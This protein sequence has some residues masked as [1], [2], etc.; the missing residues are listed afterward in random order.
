MDAKVGMP[1]AQVFPAMRELLRQSVVETHAHVAIVAL[2]DIASEGIGG[3]LSIPVVYPAAERNARLITR[4]IRKGVYFAVETGATKLVAGKIKL[5]DDDRP[6]MGLLIAAPMY[7]S[8]G[9]PWGAIAILKAT[10]EVEWATVNV[11]EQCARAVTN[12]LIRDCAPRAQAEPL[13]SGALIS[14]TAQP[15]QQT[16]PQTDFLLHELRVPLSTV[17]Y[18][19]EAL[20]QRHGP[21]WEHDGERLLRIAQSGVIEAQS[22][23]RSMKQWPTLGNDVDVPG[24][25]AVSVGATVEL[26]LNLLPAARYRVVQKQQ[27]DLPPVRGNESWITQVLVN[28]LENAL[29]YS[30]PHRD[31]ELTSHQIDSNFVLIRVRSWPSHNEEPERDHG[32]PFDGQISE[33]LGLNIARYFVASMG[34]EIWMERGGSDGSDSCTV[35]FVLPIMPAQSPTNADET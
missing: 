17:T 8:N 33:G 29:K 10:T 21:N 6:H 15:H 34:G 18:A 30:S 23:V 3:A 5:S 28:L 7:T 11:V 27:P 1:V 16:M 9:I 20:A 19:L 4:W 31:I 24:S 12:I 35:K 2:V 22:I 25:E 14:P 13:A 32:Q 26:A